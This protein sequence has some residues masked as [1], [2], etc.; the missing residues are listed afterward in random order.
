VVNRRILT[1][2]DLVIYGAVLIQPKVTYTEVAIR[3][4]V[5]ALVGCVR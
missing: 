5:G 1:L 2:W 3:R 4:R